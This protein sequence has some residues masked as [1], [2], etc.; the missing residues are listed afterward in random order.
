MGI[1]QLLPLVP[2]RRFLQVVRGPPCPFLGG[3]PLSHRLRRSISEGPS[4]LLAVFGWRPYWVYKVPVVI[5]SNGEFFILDHVQDGQ[6]F[7]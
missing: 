1:R 3:S 5:V 2:L 4:W 6:V 7:L